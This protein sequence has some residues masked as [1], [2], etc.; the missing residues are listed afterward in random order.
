[1][2]LFTIIKIIIKATDLII[3]ATA[4]FDNKNH[5][6]EITLT[7]II[8]VAHKLVFCLFIYLSIK[9]NYSPTSENFQPYNEKIYQRS[10]MFRNA[11]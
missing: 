1:M 8:K 10:F 2:H 3:K 5:D 7:L 4:R 6:R 11:K 9:K